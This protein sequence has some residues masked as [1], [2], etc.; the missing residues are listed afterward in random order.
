MDF[1]R[2]WAVKQEMPG[3]ALYMNGIDYFFVSDK[4]RKTKDVVA[5]VRRALGL[6][7]A[8]DSEINRRLERGWI[9]TKTLVNGSSFY[10]ISGNNYGGHG[11]FVG[12]GKT[13][14]FVD[15]NAYHLTICKK[16]VF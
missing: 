7:A 12:D 14:V 2:L 16:G 6:P 13:L 3:F 10:E 4:S 15:A 11:S 5:A 8:A 1:V 9:Q